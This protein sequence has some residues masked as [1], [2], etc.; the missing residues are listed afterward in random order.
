MKTLR[1]TIQINLWYDDVRDGT[2][3]IGLLVYW[4]VCHKK[5]QS[6]EKKKKNYQP[7]NKNLWYDHKNNYYYSSKI[8]PR[9]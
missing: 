4:F 9:F 7:L 5:V 1:T 2:K 3:L 8:F 6:K